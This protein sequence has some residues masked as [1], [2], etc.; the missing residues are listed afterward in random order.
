[1]LN[2]L[3]S[4]RPS[5]KRLRSSAKRGFSMIEIIIVLGILG[6]MVSVGAASFI[7]QANRNKLYST[8]R[9]MATT[10]QQARQMAIAMRQERRVVIDCGS[11]DGFPSSISGVRVDPVR[12]WIE[13]KRCEQLAFEDD[14]YCVDQSGDLPN[15]I[16]LTDVENMPDG[17]MIAL[18]DRVP[19]LGDDSSIFYVE[20]S[21]R[22]SVSK[23]YFEGEE[24]NTQPNEIEPLIYITRDNEMFELETRTVNYSDAAP[25]M[26][27]W[28]ER[29]SRDTGGTQQSN[30]LN[31]F[32]RYKINT[33]EIIRL[34]GR[35]RRY[36]YA[37]LG[38]YPLD[39][40]PESNEKIDNP[41]Q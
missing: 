10:L 41:G 2:A 19:G 40:P 4:N 14:A 21:P 36:D 17:V 22:G 6:V 26:P 38:P 28:Q 20:F 35:T 8:S 30:Y 9:M 31:D 25:L 32:E 12:I 15:K 3:L 16:E 11:L 5:N 1:M 24:S 13:G 37:V 33:I 7:T 39:H 34:T 29:D 27:E 23:V 18:D